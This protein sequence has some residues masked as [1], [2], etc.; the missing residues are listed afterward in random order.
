MTRCAFVADVNGDTRPDLAVASSERDHVDIFLGDRR[1]GFNRTAGSPFGVSASV[2]FY[3]RVLRLADVNNDRRLDIMTAN[4]R[5][6][7]FGI[8]FGDGQGRFSQG[9]TVRRESNGGRY[10]FAFGDVDGDGHVDVIVAG[11]VDDITPEPGPLSI[12]RGDGKGGFREMGPPLTVSPGP[13]FVTLAD[14]SGDQRLD[15]VITHSGTNLL[16]VLVNDGSGTFTRYPGSPFDIRTEAF[17]VVVA[18]IDGD[19]GADLLAATENSA[20]VLLG[21]GRGGFVPG[22]GSPFQ[23]GPGAYNIEAGD[24]NEDG[25]LDV[26]TSS[27]EGNTVTVLLRR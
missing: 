23:A 19:G 7:T 24:I 1:G 8:L 22:P 17:A 15:I 12:L 9:P 14:V 25:R 10:A 11:R 16:S 4:G 18:D 27:F 20:T 21:D 5:D 26:V 13:R 3:T 6:N 2:E